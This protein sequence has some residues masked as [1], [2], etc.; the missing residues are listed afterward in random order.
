MGDRL[1]AH[2][3]SRMAIFDRLVD[4]FGD[5]MERRQIVNDFNV[6]SRRA[7][8]DGFPFMLKAQITRGDSQ[9]KHQF[10]K[11][12]A[13]GFR[14]KTTGGQSMDRE[15]CSMV[16]MIILSNQTLVRRLI[17]CGFDTIEIY[18]DGGDGYTAALR[19]LLLDE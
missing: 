19:Q 18:G 3:I 11:W 5:A 14:I 16:A 7:W 13:S 15:R 2:Y 9:N 8:D 17:R 6:S 4:W 12:L 1:E 10:S